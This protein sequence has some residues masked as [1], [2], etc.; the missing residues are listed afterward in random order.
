MA[1]IGLEWYRIAKGRTEPKVGNMM[2]SPQSHLELEHEI[3]LSDAASVVQ[4]A[5]SE[6]A[7]RVYL[8]EQTQHRSEHG[9]ST[10]SGLS[11]SCREA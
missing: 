1:C 3:K 10:P 9:F 11:Q 6:L 7:A 2:S 4:P 8:N 5:G